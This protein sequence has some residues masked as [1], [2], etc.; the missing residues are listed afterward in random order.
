VVSYAAGWLAH[1]HGDLT[2]VRQ[3]MSPLAV[4]VL[5]GDYPPELKLDTLRLLQGMLGD[6]G[7]SERHPAA[8]DGYAPGLDLR[9]LE[10]ELDEVRVQLADVYP[11]GNPLVDTELSRVLAM[12]SPTNQKLLDKIVAKLTKNSD[13]I[14]DIHHLLVAARLPVT[15]SAA[16]REALAAALVGL[17]AKFTQ[18][19]LPQD[20]SWN[21]RMRDLYTRLCELDE[22][23][24][25][26]LVD[27]PGFGRPSHVLF[28]SQM[29]PQRLGDA[30]GAFVRQAQADKEYPWTNDVVFLLGA[31]DDAAHRA[32]VRGLYDRLPV[33][34]AVLMTLSEKPD[35]A[36][37]A[38]FREGLESSQAEVLDGC[39]TALEKLPADPGAGEQLALLR[40]VRR[41]GADEREYGFRERAVKLLER[42]TQHTEPFV[43]GKPG[44]QPQSAAVAAWTQWVGQ[45]WPQESAASLGGDAE[46]AQL[47]KL[48]SQ[49]DWASGDAARGAK[50]YE[51]RSCAQCHGGRSALGP[52]LN[53]VAGRFSREDLFTAIVDPN[54]DV[55]ARYQTTL[56]ETRQGKT[57]SGLIVYE[58]V[59]GLLLRNATQQ[60]F[61]IETADI[62]EHRRSPVSL[63]PAGL[64]KGLPPG[65]YA[66]LYAYLATLGRAAPQ[67]NAAATSGAR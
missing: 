55:S 46:V 45:R 66:D 27:V 25:P 7:P 30:I 24:A 13:P 41:L 6:L 42:N 43:F 21:D 40:A 23:L 53:G 14:D 29:P 26:V 58:S 17:D 34:G 16:Q 62:E 32:L 38:W 15:R 5:R 50:L 8:F 2:K 64:L 59:D 39:L 51:T 36:D 28:M 33:R 10:R 11:T 54:R 57:Y 49:V 44:H 47:P 60:T 56:I 18:G 65:D 61:R 35:A 4:A 22:F 20:S 37:R 1:S 3:A 31:S 67:A 9:P 63:M 52:D 48:L 19:K 12:L